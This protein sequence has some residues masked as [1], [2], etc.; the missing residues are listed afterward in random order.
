[1]LLLKKQIISN[2]KEAKKRVY[3]LIYFLLMRFLAVISLKFGIFALNE[4]VYSRR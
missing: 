2:Y 1:M 3:L 4:E